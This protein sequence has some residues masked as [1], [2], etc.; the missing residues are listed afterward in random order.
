MYDVKW[1]KIITML[2]CKEAT[3]QVCKL[4]NGIL[5]SNVNETVLLSNSFDKAVVL[6][7]ND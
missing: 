4:V 6:A 7:P 3:K 5:L 2:S 1:H